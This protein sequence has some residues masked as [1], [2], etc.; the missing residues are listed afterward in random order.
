MFPATPFFEEALDHLMAGRQ[1]DVGRNL[2]PRY[3]SL[4]RQSRCDAQGIFAFRDLPAGDWYL[5]TDNFWT[6]GG[7]RKRDGLLR[8]VAVGEGQ[9]LQVLLT[10]TDR[11]GR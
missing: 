6:V 5:V 10:E 8:R 9:D 2:D 3:K 7:T 1:P 11:V 4:L